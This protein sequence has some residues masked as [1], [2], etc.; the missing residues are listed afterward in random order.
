MHRYHLLPCQGEIL[1]M[2]RANTCLFVNFLSFQTNN[3][4]FTNQCVNYPTAPGFEPTT[5]RTWVISHGHHTRAPT[6]RLIIV[7]LFCFSRQTDHSWK[8]KAKSTF[9]MKMDHFDIVSFIEAI[10]RIKSQNWPMFLIPHSHSNG[11]YWG[12]QCHGALW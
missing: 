12:L 10:I 9:Y 5:S 1:F 6:Q 8:A 2:K 4:I 3:T 7:F 11:F